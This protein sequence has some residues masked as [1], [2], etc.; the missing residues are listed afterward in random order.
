MGWFEKSLLD[1]EGGGAMASALGAI[2]AVFNPGA[3][4]A[5]EELEANHERVEEKPTPGDKAL[6]E[7]SITIRLD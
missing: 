3:A 5:R 4:R 2:D 6:R 7:G 1:N